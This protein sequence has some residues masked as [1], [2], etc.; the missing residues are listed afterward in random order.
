MTQT[1]GKDSLNCQKKKYYLYLKLVDWQG[2]PL[3]ASETGTGDGSAFGQFVVEPKAAGSKAMFVDFNKDG[4]AYV[5]ELPPGPV[6]FRFIGMERPL[7]N[8]VAN[9]PYNKE[10]KEKEP[11]RDSD[12]RPS[13]KAAPGGS[14][15]AEV[16]SA[17]DGQWYHFHSYHD[18]TAGIELLVD[19]ENQAPLF[20]KIYESLPGFVKALLPFYT[21]HTI[22]VKQDLR[23]YMEVYVCDKYL[24]YKDK[25]KTIVDSLNTYGHVALAVVVPGIKKQVYDFGR[26][27]D[28]DFESSY[29]LND[30]FNYSSW[31]IL[32]VWDDPETYIEHEKS[33]KR[34]IVGFRYYL[35]KPQARLILDFFQKKIDRKLRTEQEH[36]GV[37][38]SYCLKDEYMALSSNC[39][40]MSIDGMKAT[41][42]KGLIVGR[43]SLVS[44]VNVVRGNSFCTF[45][46]LYGKTKGAAAAAYQY[47]QPIDGLF[48]P[49]DFEQMLLKNDERRY[50]EPFTYGDE[51]PEVT[52]YYNSHPSYGGAK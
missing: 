3:D 45:R 5:G 7:E 21:P 44:G 4:A 31:G 9:I 35:S 43:Y 16:T 29:P 19:K 12:Y 20:Q 6:A 24:K 27:S 2:K 32:N 49:L 42:I 23:P 25:E 40:T 18:L 52:A 10:E 1:P 11:P 14:S 28:A 22:E 37:K 30:K 33:Y 47:I 46:G 39:T 38:V 41:G 8:A 48:M 15:Q 50:D 13:G 17:K 51:A 36:D 34:R 26:Y